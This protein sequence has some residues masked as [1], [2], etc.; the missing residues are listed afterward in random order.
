MAA[1]SRRIAW[2]TVTIEFAR[3][4]LRLG[5]P[6][7]DL[8]HR[9][10][11]E[12]QF[13]RAPRHMGEHVEEDDR[14]EEDQR[15]HAQNGRAEPARTERGLQFGQVHP[16]EHDAGQ[17]PDHGEDGRHQIGR[18]G[19]AALQRAQDLADRLAVVVGRTP[20]RGGV[21]ETGNVVVEG[22]LTG[23][24]APGRLGSRLRLNLLGRRLSRRRGSRVLGG[25]GI[26]NTERVLDRRQR[27]F[28]RVLHFLRSVRH[29]GRRLVLRN[30]PTRPGRHPDRATST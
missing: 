10:G 5:Q 12:A 6:H 16:A 28:R 13:L 24:G 2:P 30:T 20:H 23:D 21:L 26:P 7:R 4:R 22:F 29:V 25:L 3:H 19:R 18:A 8:G 17:H 1:T 27:R 15:Q 9:L 11:D 14:R